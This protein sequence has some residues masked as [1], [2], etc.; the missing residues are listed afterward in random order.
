MNEQLAHDFLNHPLD[1]LFGGLLTHT[2]RL[3]NGWVIQSDFKPANNQ[4]KHHEPNYS[5]THAVYSDDEAL[6]LFKQHKDF[7]GNNEQTVFVIQPKS[8]H[9]SYKSFI[10]ITKSPF[11][12]QSFVQFV[13]IS[14]LPVMCQNLLMQIANY[15]N[16][17]NR[18]PKDLLFHHL[19]IETLSP[20]LTIN[21]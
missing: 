21:S 9:S 16:G 13:E 20:Y 17:V 1:L 3:G 6:R 8:L 18:S 19:P 10:K 2:K 12:K 7:I 5:I 11:T 15:K 14:N 4:L